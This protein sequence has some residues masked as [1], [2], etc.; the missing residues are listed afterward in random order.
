[1]SLY[2]ELKR[3]NVFRVAIAYLA[4]AWLLIEVAGTLFPAFGVPDW[5]VRFVVIVVALGFLP[6]LIVS[7]AYEMTPEGL[8]REKDVVRDTST[9]HLTAKRLDWITITLM[10]V[11]VVFT[12]A[13]RLW[14]S[15]RIAEQLATPAA[16]VADNNDTQESE[17]AEPRYSSNSIAVLPFVNIS[18]DAANEYFSDGISEELLNMLAKIPEL[19]VIA[20]TSSFAYKGKDVKIAD[21]ARELNVGHILEGSV[22]KAGNQVR[23]TAQLIHT[24]DSSHLWSATY[25]RT[26]DD[27]FAIQ[28]E[29]AAVVVVQ[30]KVKLLGEAPTAVETDPKAFSLYLRARQVGRQGARE[31]QQQSIALYQQALAIAPDFAAAWVG[32]AANYYQAAYFGALPYDEAAALTHEAI[33]KALEINPSNAQ[34]HSI[35]GGIAM[36][37]DGDLAAAAQNFQQSLQLKPTD[38]DILSM[39]SLLVANLG[40]MDEAIALMEYVVARDPLNPRSHFSLGDTYL[41]AGHPDNAIISFRTALNLSP[42]FISAHYRIGVAL[43]AKNAPEAALAEIQKEPNRAYR[44]FGLS[45]VYHALGQTTEANVSLAD[46]IERYEQVS[47]YNIAFVLAFR[48]EADLAFEWLDKAVK[49]KDSGL[50]STPVET[51]F[52]NI[53]SDPRWLPFLESIG[54]SPEQLAAIK[55]KVTLPN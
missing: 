16:I 13:D 45:M 1:M 12:L 33:N 24:A 30:L 47:A 20:R 50:S 22:R 31:A 21:I 6:A 32:Q 10:V 37:Y 9:T 27:I 35:R 5:G 19:R 51:L 2:N 55:F 46:L 25:D 48:D 41:L 43:L 17:P 42:E 23:I 44:L 39:A 26:L 18:D 53:H 8:K 15:Q 54:K 4:G 14:L 52:S 29:I 49:F 36:L 7:W 3:R 28:D 40:R 34:A 38:P 11:V